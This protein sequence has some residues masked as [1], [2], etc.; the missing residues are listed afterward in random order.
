MNIKLYT[1]RS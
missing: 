1:R